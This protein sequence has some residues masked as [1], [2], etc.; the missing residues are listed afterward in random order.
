[1]PHF[2]ILLLL[3]MVA[4]TGALLAASARADETP[5]SGRSLSAHDALVYVGTYTGKESKGIYFYRL[6]D[7]T[8]V[9]M[10]LAGETPSPSF[11]AIDQKRRLLFAVNE[12][13][14]FQGKPSGGVS[15]FAI[16]P[17]TGKLTLLSQQASMGTGPCHIALDKEIT[18]AIVANYSSGS[19]AVFPISADGKLGEASDVK[20]H[21]GSS[22]NPQRQKGP[23]AHCITFDP[24]GRFVFVCDLGLDKV[25]IYRFDPEHG[26]LTPNDPAFAEAPKGAGPRHMVFRPDGK[27]AYVVNE[28]GSTVT[29]YAYDADKGRL[30]TIESISTLPADFNGANTTAEIAVHPSGKFLYASNR[31][32]DSIALFKIDPA[33][34]KLTWVEA[35]KTGGKTPRFFAIESTGKLMVIANQNSSTLVLAPIDAASGAIKPS[36]ASI[37]CPS[38]VSAVFLP[39]AGGSE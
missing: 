32:S 24:A 10:G 23:H 15:S 27:F 26:K 38:P 17:A 37:P 33:S 31:G 2:N 14:T 28:M 34:G 29:T 4:L 11:L 8:L 13:N 39:P 7:T 19:V 22:V 9:P 3:A 16:D 36:A 21:Q 20:Q 6:Q 18:N 35:Q 1:M 5:R 12:T 30:R 25:M